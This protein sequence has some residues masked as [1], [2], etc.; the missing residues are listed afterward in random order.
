MLYDFTLTVGDDR[1]SLQPIR[2][3]E[4]KKPLS[5]DLIKDINKVLS[6]ALD[7]TEATEA[8]GKE[9]YLHFDKAWV[10]KKAKHDETVQMLLAY[11]WMNDTKGSIKS[12]DP[13]EISKQIIAD[14]QAADEFE[15]TFNEDDFSNLDFD[16]FELIDNTVNNDNLKVPIGSNV[17]VRGWNAILYIYQG[18]PSVEEMRN[19]YN[20]AYLREDVWA[21]DEN[22]IAV[23]DFKVTDY[24]DR[25]EVFPLPKDHDYKY[26]AREKTKSSSR[27][28]AFGSTQKQAKL[29]LALML[30]FEDIAAKPE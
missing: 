2:S 26:F 30:A 7:T 1:G 18:R 5:E 8:I 19:G 3:Y 15:Y 9:V 25:M 4:S 24:K 27:K 29:R 11:D 14:L 17:Y 21:T 12:Q 6:Q 16:A 28:E 10:K 23:D 13:R 22:I 20:P